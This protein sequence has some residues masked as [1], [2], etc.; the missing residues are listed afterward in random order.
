MA[1][2][3]YGI[4]SVFFGKTASMANQKECPAIMAQKKG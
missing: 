4:L 2:L 3:F 1:L